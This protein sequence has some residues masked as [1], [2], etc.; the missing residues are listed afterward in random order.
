[1]SFSEKCQE[2]SRSSAGESLTKAAIREIF[3][4][5]LIRCSANFPADFATSPYYCE[6]SVI[7]EI[8]E[9]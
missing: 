6:C 1:M 3:S 2:Y 9:R 8:I 7:S 5:F 4:K